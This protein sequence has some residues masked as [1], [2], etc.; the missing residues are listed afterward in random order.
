MFHADLVSP[1]SPPVAPPDTALAQPPDD[2]PQPSQTRATLERSRTLQHSPIRSGPRVVIVKWDRLFAETLRHFARETIP[3]AEVEIAGSGAEALD[4]LH[5]TPA[6]L[7]IFGLTLPDCD[8]LDLV[9]KVLAEKLA[10][11]SLVVSGRQDERVR[12]RMRQIRVDGYFDTEHGG[13]DLLKTALRSIS[14]GRNFFCT[15]TLSAPHSSDGPLPLDRLL[16]PTEL[17]VLAVI[18]DGSDNSVAAERLGMAGNTVQTHRQHIMNKLAVQTRVDLVR[19][20]IRRGI[21]RIMPDRILRPGFEEE[22]KQRAS[23]SRDPFGNQ[24]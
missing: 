21:I 5:A 12:H 13:V 19:V 14:A 23:R 3:C 16:S 9:E 20:A 10:E 7:A 6:T 4:R 18:G 17:Q 8:G 2:P 24:S 15:P 22:L 11:R 1:D